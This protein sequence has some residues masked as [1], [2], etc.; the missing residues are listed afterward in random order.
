MYFIIIFLLIQVS[1]GKQSLS[2]NKWSPIVHVLVFISDG[3]PSLNIFLTDGLPSLNIFWTDGLPWMVNR[4]V[5]DCLAPHQRRDGHFS[6]Q[7]TFDAR[8][9]FHAHF[10]K[11]A[12][13]TGCHSYLHPTQS[14]SPDTRSTRE[15]PSKPTQKNHWS[16]PPAGLE[17]WILV[18]GGDGANHYT[19]L[20]SVIVHVS[21]GQ[22]IIMLIVLSWNSGLKEKCICEWLYVRTS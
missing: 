14:H 21:N 17:P 5:P 18:V 10:C 11:S 2:N 7:L 8:V 1:D 12:H 13:F 22:I 20:G 4:T 9:F 3:L 6:E 19:N 15:T 16:L